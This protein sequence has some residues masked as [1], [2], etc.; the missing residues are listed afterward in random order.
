[1][2]ASKCWKW[3][4]NNTT[5]IHASMFTQ[6]HTHNIMPLKLI[7]S[8][9]TRKH[10][11]KDIFANVCTHTYYIRA[12]IH[13]LTTRRHT[14][15]SLCKIIVKVLLP[16]SS[17]IFS[18]S[19]PNYFLIHSYE[20]AR[21]HTHTHTP[22][23]HTFSRSLALLGYLKIAEFRNFAFSILK[24]PLWRKFHR[25]RQIHYQL[26]SEQITTVYSKGEREI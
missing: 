4:N 14:K 15:N 17:A 5:Y 26:S 12:H 20:Y 1:M 7:S 6:F 9:Y 25:T 23:T 18:R 11:F 13:T 3:A 10:T 24:C 2:S 8:K 22:H 21:T 16:C 19:W